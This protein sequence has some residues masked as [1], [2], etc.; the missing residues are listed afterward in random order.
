MPQIQATRAVLYASAVPTTKSDLARGTRLSWRTPSRNSYSIVFTLTKM[1]HSV[2]QVIITA[3]VVNSRM[4]RLC[5]VVT[6]SSDHRA[7][8]VLQRESQL[9]GELIDR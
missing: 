5:N 6:A 2:S 3:A 1:I 4:S 8:G 9:F 7:F